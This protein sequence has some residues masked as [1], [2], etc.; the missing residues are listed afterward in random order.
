MEEYEH[1]QG[2]TLIEILI[3]RDHRHSA[4]SR[5]EFANREKE[6]GRAHKYDLRN[7]VTAQER[8]SRITKTI[9]GGKYVG[10]GTSNQP[11]LAVARAGWSSP[12]R[13]QHSSARVKDGRRWRPPRQPTPPPP[14]V[15]SDVAVCT[16][17]RV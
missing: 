4:E 11:G 1:T 5:S 3:W 14:P 15:A 13:Q 17:D 10:D 16:S 8:S 2:L 7:L 12:E 9:A 6:G